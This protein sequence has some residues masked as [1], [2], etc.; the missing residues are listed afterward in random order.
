MNNNKT[1]SKQRKNGYQYIL[2][3]EEIPDTKKK[4]RPVC[5]KNAFSLDIKIFL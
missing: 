1:R 4:Q 2:K 3:Q 5:I